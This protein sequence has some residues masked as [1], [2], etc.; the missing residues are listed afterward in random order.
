MERPTLQQLSYLVALDEHRHFGR[1]AEASFVTQPA[2]SN[3]IREL[4]RRLGATLVER[5]GRGVVFT[6]AGEAVVERARTVLRTV[7]ELVERARTDASG[8]TGP[9]RIGVIPTM[10]PYLLPTIVPV[11]AA[12]HPDADIRLRELRTEELVDE[13]HAGRLDLGLLARPARARAGLVVEDVT[14]D[15]FLLAVATDH[16]LASSRRPI[17]LDALAAYEVLLLEDG[18]CLRDQALEVCRLAGADTRTVHDTSLAT[19]VQIVSTGRGVTLLPSSAADVEARPGNGVAT[20]PFRKPEPSR[21]IAL[22]WRSTSSRD[23][24]FRELVGLVR[25]ALEDE[26]HARTGTSVR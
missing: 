16:P 26:A 14:P 12:R 10:A 20:R 24:A 11:V 15:P 3:Q 2:L 1:A 23:V 18:H 19:L 5:T 7:D 8:I 6:S 22:A 17:D 25:A 9:L 21:T 4:E 13:L